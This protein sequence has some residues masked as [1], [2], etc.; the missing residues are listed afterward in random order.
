M[1]YFIS[2]SL[3][4]YFL[5]FFP[6]ANAGICPQA[7][8][9]ER[10]VTTKLR[11]EKQGESADEIQVYY[12]L[13][14]AFDP[15]KPTLLVINGGPG[16]D[17]SFIDEFRG[18]ALDR[19]M[20]IVGFDHRGLGCTRPLS[21]LDTYYETG[22]YSMSRAADDIEAIRMDLLGEHGKWFVYGISY[23]TFLG[24]QYAIKY[25]HYIKSMILDSAFHDSKAID[26]ARQQFMSLFIRN[27]KV[28]SDLFDKVEQKYGELRPAI[29]RTIF[30]YSYGYDGRTLETRRF[31]EKLAAAAS[32][33]D[34][35]KIIG[36]Q[37]DYPM[38]GMMRHI[39]CEEL[40]DYYH[41][42]Y[43]FALFNDCGAF[44]NH[45]KP[46]AFGDDLKQLNVP[47]FIWGGRFDPVTPI[48]AMREM[49]ELLPQSLLWEH[50]HAGH[51]LIVESST[52][53]LKL[54]DMFFSDRSKTD[55]QDLAYSKACQDEPSTNF[56]NTKRF[57]KKLT[58]PGRRFPIF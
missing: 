11:V 53:A 25:P 27:D 6:I 14:N 23:G 3:L 1:N 12:K 24:Q 38:T 43:Y 37:T 51:G 19:K 36:I 28:I 30:S 57:L 35:E 55:I 7:S 29:L 44:K 46:M 5:S 8:D 21:P 54:A 40:W 42:G 4:F 48:Q 10:Y 22:L 32:Q 52:C 45:R 9:T 26:I 49:H 15:Q 34:A 56:E 47:I 18:T 33:E 16:G 58:L 31:L 41:D 13:L 2:L 17:H 39:V 50:P 20:N